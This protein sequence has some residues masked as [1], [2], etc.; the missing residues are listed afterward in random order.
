M[1]KRLASNPFVVAG[2]TAGLVFGWQA[3]TRPKTLQQVAADTK[4]AAVIV[5]MTDSMGTAMGTGAGWFYNANG[6]IATANHAAQASW[7]T[8]Q[9]VFAD[10][11][12]MPRKLFSKMRRMI[13]AFCMSMASRTTRF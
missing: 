3:L 4:A 12:N 13:S 9:V 5:N 1:I 7:P 10:G 8:T 6:D 11:S 2:L